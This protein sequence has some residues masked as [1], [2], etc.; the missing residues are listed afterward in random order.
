MIIAPDHDGPYPLIPISCSADLDFADHSSNISLWLA[1][2][3]A[4]THNVIIR[5]L[6]SVWLNAPLLLPGDESDFVGYALACVSF[7]R[8]HHRA[9]EEIAF[10]HLQVKLDMR[11]NVV[12]HLAFEAPLKQFESYLEHV[13]DGAEKYDAEKLLAYRNEVGSIMVQHLHDEV[14]FLTCLSGHEN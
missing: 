5:A 12:D 2:E 8:E 7:V 6:N 1:D 14:R 4:L 9:Q 3:L 10:P 11:S 13:R